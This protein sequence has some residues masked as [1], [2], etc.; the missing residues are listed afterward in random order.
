MDL[1][2]QLRAFIFWAWASFLCWSCSD[3]AGRVIARLQTIACAKHTARIGFFYPSVLERRAVLHAA[4]AETLRKSVAT[5]VFHF[6][7]L[8]AS[9]KIA[10][11]SFSKAKPLQH[12]NDQMITGPCGCCRLGVGQQG[13]GDIGRAAPFVSWEVELWGLSSAVRSNHCAKGGLW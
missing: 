6:N 3:K 1:E 8:L 9:G 2:R 7:K 11:S 4:L 13:R 10:C 12:S 5:L